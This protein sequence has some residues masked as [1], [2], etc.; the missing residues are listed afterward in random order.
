MS[1]DRISLIS[2][3]YHIAALGCF[4]RSHALHCPSVFVAL[5]VTALIHTRVI[6]AM[7]DASRRVT[8]PNSLEATDDDYRLLHDRYKAL[9]LPAL[10]VGRINELPKL[11]DQFNKSIG[12]KLLLVQVVSRAGDI[13]EHK[14]VFHKRF[15]KRR[16]S[17]SRA[18]YAVSTRPHVRQNVHGEGWVLVVSNPLSGRRW[19][20]DLQITLGIDRLLKQDVQGKS[21][22]EK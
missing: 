3:R 11:T 5:L 1:S 6:A 20:D 13:T 2:R 12:D 4:T 19:P 15:T 14:T 7:D 8:D 22:D 21:S 16:I 18:N 17:I 9:I 10:L